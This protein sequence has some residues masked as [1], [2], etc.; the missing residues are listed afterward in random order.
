M[1]LGG[2]E[3]AISNPPAL[4]PQRL[5]F[6]KIPKT[7]SSS[8]A[9]MLKNCFEKNDVAY[10]VDSIYRYR[11]T[12]ETQVTWKKEIKYRSEITKTY[13]THRTNY[14]KGWTVKVWVGSY[15]EIPED[16]PITQTRL[17][18]SD[19]WNISVPTQAPRGTCNGYL[20][21]GIPSRDSSQG[22]TLIQ[23]YRK[24]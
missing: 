11:M 16:N 13:F 21:S 17:H 19:T 5:I 6:A 14:F 24:K 4:G 15:Q 10:V 23:G 8:F 7:G 20:S 2:E 22:L 3:P 12:A 1:E 9:A 18:F